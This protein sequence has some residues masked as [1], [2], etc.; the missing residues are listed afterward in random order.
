MTSLSTSRNNRKTSSSCKTHISSDVLLRKRAAFLFGQ[1]QLLAIS[2]MA[3]TMLILARGLLSLALW[4]RGA[5][6]TQRKSLIRYTSRFCQHQLLDSIKTQR[7]ECCSTF[8]GELLHLLQ[9]FSIH[10]PSSLL[11]RSWEAQPLKCSRL[12]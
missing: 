8:W 7:R 5:E 1:R 2:N 6:K 12:Q 9:Y 4:E 11:V 10:H 3:S